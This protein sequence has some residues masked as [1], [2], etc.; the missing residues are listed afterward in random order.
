[1][2]CDG[3]CGNVNKDNSGALFKEAEKKWIK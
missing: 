1:M 2:L 3:D